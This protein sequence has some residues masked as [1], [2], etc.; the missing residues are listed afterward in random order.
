M[1]YA[2]TINGN[3]YNLTSSTQDVNLTLSRTGGQGAKGDSITNASID[4]NGDFHVIISNSA[5]Q[6]IQDVNLGGANLIASITALKVATEAA[7]DVVD[8]VFLGSKSSAPSVD[9]DGNALQNGAMYFDTTTSALGVYNVNTW[10]YPIALATTSAAAAASSASSAAS[11]ATNALLRAN[12]ANTSAINAATSETNA[13]TSETN[14]ATSETNAANSASTATTKAADA[15]T[16]ETNAAISETNAS[17]S[18]T[19]AASSATSASNSATSAT[20][21]KNAAATSETNAANSASSAGSSATNAANSATTAGSH[22][23]NAA[24]NAIS[25]ANSATSASSSASDALN[26]KTD[27]ATDRAAVELLFDNFD[28][29]FLGTKTSDPTVDNDGDT[30]VEGAMY[31]NSNT[32]VIKFYNG[33]SWEAP[34][35][36]ASNSATAAATS[37]TNAAASAAASLTSANNAATSESNAATSEINAS[38]SASTATTQATNSANS[39]SA[40][41]TSETNAANS[42][43]SSANSATA[44]AT[45]AIASNTAKTAALAAQSAAETAETNAETAETNAATSATASAN[46]ATAAQTAQTAAETAETNA[47]TA[48]TNAASSATSASNFATAA[49]TAQ[50]AAETALD[51]FDDR[52]L[53]VKSSDPSVDNDGDAL[54]AG[55]LYFNLNGGSLRVYDGTQW[56]PTAA[57]TE[58][59]Q[60]VIGGLLA[61]G[62][63]IDIDYDDANNSLII[64]SEGSE[65]T[66]TN[67]TG[68]TITKGTP[69]YQSGS[70]GQTIEITP[71]QA[72]SSSTMPA[73]GI[74][75]SDIA[76]G[77]TGVVSIGGRISNLNTSSYNDGD[78]LYIGASG[79]LVNT[80]PSGEANLIQNIAK[81]V[82]SNQSSGSIIIT[83]AGRS[84]ATPNL[85]NGAFFL[86]NSSNQAVATDFDTAVEANSKIS[87]IESNATADQTGAE[88]KALYEAEANAFTDAKNTKLAGIESNATADQTDAEIRAAVEAASNSNVFTDADHTKLNNIEANADITDTANVTAAGALMDSE[89]TNLTQVKAFD[90]SDYA[91][92]AQGTTADA[93]LPKAGG[94]MTGNL[95]LN[96]NPSANL[97]AATKQYVDSS[98]SNLVDSAPSAL[99]TLNELAAALGDDANFSTTITNSIA[100]K[101]SLSGGQMTGNITMSGSQTVDGRDLSVDGA[102]LDGIASGATAYSNSSVDTH[103]NTS[104]ASNGQYLSWN[105]SDYD[106]A[107]VSTDLVSDTSP[108][109]GG[110]LDA[111]NNAI[112]LGDNSDYFGNGSE[113]NMIIMGADEDFR[114]FKGATNNYIRSENGGNLLIQGHSQVTLTSNTGENMA[115][116]TKDGS[117]R[118]FHDGSKKVETSSTG[119]DITGDITFDGSSD[120]KVG[121]ASSRTF[122]TG[123]LG[124][125]LRAG[126]NTKVAATTT[127]VELTGATV[128]NGDFTFTG[129]SYN[130]VWDKSD[131]ALE[132]GDNA[133][134]K[135]GTSGDL[136]LYHDGSNSYL[137][138]AGSGD[139]RIAGNDVHI[140]NGG[141]GSMAKFINGGASELYHNTSKKFETTSSGVTVTGN[142]V[143]SGTVDGRDIASDG[144]KLDTIETNATA[145]QTKAD[146]DALN[147]NAD[148]LDGQHGSY[149]TG[150]TDTAI[151]NLID[152]SPSALN[153][154]NELAAALGDDANFSTTI[155]NSIA[156]KMPKAGGTFTGDVTFQGD[157]YN[158]VWDKSTDDLVFD[159]EARLDFGG[160]ASIRRRSSGIFN[161]TGSTS[162]DTYFNY[163]NSLLF[164]R[165]GS[166]TLSLGSSGINVIG[167]VSVSGTVD[168]RDVATDGT[169]LDGIEASADV[170]DTTNVTA[171]GALMTTGGSVTGDVSF[172]DNDKAIFGTGSDLEIYHDGTYS[173]IKDDTSA[174][175]RFQNGDFQFYS[176]NGFQNI[177]K[178]HQTD[179][180]ELY[181]QNSKKFETTATGISV[182]GSIDVTDIATTQQNLEVD[183]AGTAVALAIALG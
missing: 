125:Q 89:V 144:T 115:Q 171:A 117:A 167:N 9:N 116:F 14:A 164:Y 55:A 78:T 21:S 137:F 17:N 159:Q 161:I 8:D 178:F 114:I 25:A 77:A 96:A 106:W 183:P 142:I 112:R 26:Y 134:L 133:R 67:N 104:T 143:V 13:A 72:G 5:G 174:Q 166:L 40:A 31:Y 57:T 150:Y 12:A 83:G 63:G 126:N 37:A 7:A 87:G 91:T 45:S 146:I 52:Y 102:K 108:Q 66:A 101:L 92:A 145:D 157:N 88:I 6:Q 153:T 3:N 10:E 140:V 1:S 95:I 43:T 162:S 103:L 165:S 11:S 19:A 93:A 60:D 16:S 46:S 47:E 81:V 179:G 84:N 30:L 138:D 42:A 15:A 99:N 160:G 105:G 147:I 69:V 156:T 158:I 123:N 54:T 94:T 154:L 97:G 168:G 119:A 151:S 76:N 124:S 176:A 100:S 170:T 53:G 34:S 74:V 33:S 75:V 163:S 130:A 177:A 172:G 90:S 2:I 141:F 70:A 122:L 36:A 71:A 24:A 49:Q 50:A 80:P 79:G 22:S 155:T 28:D 180:V 149:Y 127:G 38:N 131:N 85:D 73:I 58:A 110:D 98:V 32:N 62:N 175:M 128:Q 121:A 113:G 173:Y 29:K 64:T 51:N 27:T 111:N 136:Q 139:L 65:Q 4:S 135:F 56:N 152:S 86:G 44:S 23:A 148:L 48:E 120:E 18:A 41:A 129:A 82:K 169:K 20:A 132:F 107:T 59:I 182:T 39:A 181:Y 118:L 109:L 35:V 68:S 61:A